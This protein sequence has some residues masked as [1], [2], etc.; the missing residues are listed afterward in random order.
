MIQGAR[1][2]STSDL[3]IPATVF[4]GGHEAMREVKAVVALQF[5][6]YVS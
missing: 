6:T 1:L 2:S 3:A 5:K 4:A